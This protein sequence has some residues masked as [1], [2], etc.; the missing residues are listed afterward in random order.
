MQKLY[1]YRVIQDREKNHIT[2]VVTLKKYKSM[3]SCEKK[4]SLRQKDFLFSAEQAS[5]F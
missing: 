4:I 2:L 1:E 3:Q 5:R